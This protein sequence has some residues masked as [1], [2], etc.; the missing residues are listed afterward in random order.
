MDKNEDAYFDAWLTAVGDKWN[1]PA[2]KDIVW[3]SR[4]KK[5]PALLAKIATD[6]STPEAEKARYIRAM[7]FQKGPEKEAALVEMLTAGSK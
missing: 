7:D 4:A 6:K 1:T 5:T 3:R 2:G